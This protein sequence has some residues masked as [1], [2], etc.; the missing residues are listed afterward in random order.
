MATTMVA[1]RALFLA[2]V[3]TIAAVFLHSAGAVRSYAGV[4]KGKN[5]EF[6]RR[7]CSSTLYSSLCYTS[8]VPYANAVARDPIR[9]A[10]VATNISLARVRSVSSHVSS[11][12][13]ADARKVD[14][15]TLSALEDC[16]ETLGDAAG[17]TRQSVH[18]L[19]LLPTS[20]DKKVAWRVSNVQTWMSAAL[21]NE[22]TCMDGFTGAGNSAVKADV[23]Q[24]VR[25]AAKYTS[26]G[27]ALVNRLVQRDR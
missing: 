1:G 4:P 17:L 2:L 3:T 23:R 12:R 26:N 8:L 21:T 18:E 5:T 15:R 6:I 10:R 11:L 24:L 9:L 14:A 13:G 27:L 7:S 16:E 20:M 19:G 22:G 25:L